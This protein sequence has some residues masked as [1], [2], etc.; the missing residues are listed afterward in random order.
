MPHVVVRYITVKNEEEGRRSG[1]I[2]TVW[3]ILVLAGSVTLGIAGRALYPALKD[4]EHILPRFAAEHLPPVLA[5]VVLAAITAAIM[6]TADSQLM[7][8]ATSLVNDLWLKLTKRK[9]EGRHLVLATRL[10]ILTMTGIAILVALFNVK[11]I[12]TFVLYAW[13]ALGAA[14]SP[15]ILSMIYFRRFNK[16]GALANLIVGP[17]AVVIW[18]NIP[19]LDKA[20]Y[21]LIPAFFLSLAA[22]LIVSMM[23]REKDA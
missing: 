3:G 17:L 5:G 22:G 1:M 9:I 15:M 10:V 21:E 11:V 19:L 2:A 6:S 7:Y 16:W 13:G 4:A 8:A 12:Y 23:T 14:F 20:V 18:N